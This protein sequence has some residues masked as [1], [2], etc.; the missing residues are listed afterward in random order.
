M[1]NLG[2]V[3]GTLF[4]GLLITE[5][6]GWAANATAPVKVSNY[7]IPSVFANALYQGMSV[8]VFIRYEG[9]NSTQRSQQKIADAILTIKDNEFRLNQIALSDLPERTELS[10]QI[11]SL[12]NEMQDKSIGDGQRVYINKDAS[13]SL[14]T[15]SFYLELTVNRAAM[16]AAILPRTNMLGESTAQNLSSVLNYSMGSYYNKYENTDSAS[17]YLTLDNTWSLREHH[18]NFNGSLYG[19]GTGN[20]QGKLYRSMYERDYQGRRF[21]MGMVDT[22]NLQSI[23]SMSALNSSRIYGISYGNKS[24]S[25][26]QDN[27]LALVPVTVFL[28]A[29]GEVHVYRDGKLLSIQNFSM[30]SY[31]LDTSRLPFGIYNV[32]I[33]VVVNGR[34]VSSRT[35]NIN[36]TFARKS[37]VTGDLS[38]QNFGGS[39]EYNKMDY[40]HKYNI[41][42]GTRNTWIAGIAA[43]TS[44]PWL[45]GVNLKTTLYGFDNNG[46]NETEANVIFNNAFSFNQQ[47]LLAT[48]GSWQSTSTFNM[49][50][51]DGYGNLWGSRQYSSIGNALPMQ[52]NDYVTVGA[53]ANLRKIAPFLGTLSVSRTNNK[54][55]GSTYTN[56][57]YDQSLL[58]N[59]YATVTLRVGIQNYQYNNHENL[60]DKYVNIDISIPFSTWLSTGVSSQNG[61][62]LANATLRKSFDNSA[63]TQV[64]ASVSKQI[65]QNKNDDSRYRSD[66]YAANGYVSYNTKYNAGTVSVSRSSQHS[67]NYSLSSQGSVAWTEKNVYVGKGTQTAGLVVNT[68]FSG[69]GRMMA[70]INGQN[71]PLTGK[72]NFISLPPYAEYKV[73]LMNDKNSEDSVDIVNGRRNKVVLYPGNVSVINPEVKQLVTVFGRVKDR[74]GGYYANADIHNHIG[75][76]RTD[77]LGEFAM[78]VDKRYPVITLVDKFGGICEVDLDLTEAKGAVWVGE[79]PCEI[80]QQTA[81]VTGDVKNVY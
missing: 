58:A 36:K 62:M 32:D 43:A 48:D 63:I 47:G 81:S 8:P 38:W 30:G 11:K 17:S 25:Q 16:Q 56:V 53:N 45:S 9:D 39:L 46:V 54:Y 2:Y 37:S 76:T 5:N 74:R 34:V 41:N 66:D 78:D 67:S 51:P 44:Q 71:Y 18:L 22:W 20:Q 79:I 12:L 72:S 19:I 57:D 64:G 50:L 61:N 26:T 69:K 7:V 35:A 59:R 4:A 70:Q 10:P 60:R 42:Y 1:D 52:Q 3:K 31:E 49:S 73:E 13:L 68:N 65:K 6:Q 33:Q 15:R 21:A 40:R 14:D 24:S 55:T 77:E 27:T 28:P 29:A 80:Q 75:K 23:A